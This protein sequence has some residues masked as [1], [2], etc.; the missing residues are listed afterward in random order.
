MPT[1]CHCLHNWQCFNIFLS[2]QGYFTCQYL[3]TCSSNTDNVWNFLIIFISYVSVF[4]WL[5]YCA[6]FKCFSFLHD[7]ILYTCGKTEFIVNCSKLQTF[8]P[9]CYISVLVWVNGD[10]LHCCTILVLYISCFYR[11]SDILHF[12][13]LS[14]LCVSDFRPQ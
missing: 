1:L 14:V 9:I 11:S 4:I 12:C 2:L 3:H 7:N 6:F 8:V 13:T 5:R 10:S